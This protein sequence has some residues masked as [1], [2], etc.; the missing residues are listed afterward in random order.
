ML[1]YFIC[2]DGQQSEIA[3][4]LADGGC[5]LKKRCLTKS[6]LTSLGK[7]RKW[8]GIP[9]VTQL[10]RGTMEAFLLIT[11]DYAESPQESTF[12]LLGTT[13][14]K[15]L[16]EN[17]FG[18]SLA[19]GDLQYTTKDGISMRPDL[20]E[21]E[22]GWNILT[23][24]KVSGSYKIA[25]AI[26]LY[27]VLEEDTKNQ[28]KQRTNIT[29]PENGEQITRLKGDNKLVKVWKRDIR[30]QDCLDWIRQTNYYRLGINEMGFDVDEMR[31]QAL[32]RDG[33]LQIA[34]QRG[35]D[36]KIYMIPIPVLDDV[37]VRSYF[38]SK[39]TALLKALDDVK[40]LQP[41]TD[42]ESW[43]GRKC[44]QYCSVADKCETG[45][46]R[47]TKWMGEQA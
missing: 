11:E 29:N 43:D 1:K 8:A 39:R 23:D 45:R 31:V 27:A 28:Y 6:T 26:G 3:T 40:C 7:Q 18:N 47:R 15:N 38:V 35:L 42:E 34:Q 24:Y 33:G 25:K 44:E 32:V 5:R 13:V 37:A 10:I 14:H 36:E 4:C 41:C 12:K 19:E 22:D 16:E 30:R 46:I 2:P 21:T 17:E 9:S 20:L